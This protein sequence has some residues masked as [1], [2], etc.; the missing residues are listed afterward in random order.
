MTAVEMLHR[1]NDYRLLHTL[2]DPHSG[3]HWCFM[4]RHSSRATR[5]I[6]PAS[7]RT[8]LKELRNYQAGHV[9]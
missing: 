4:H 8:L 3:T 7:R 6:A 2:E 5:V 1:D 9:R